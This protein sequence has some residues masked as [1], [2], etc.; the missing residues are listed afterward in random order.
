MFSFDSTL[1]FN[2]SVTITYSVTDRGDPD[3]CGAPGLG[4][5][6]AETS[7]IRTITTVNPVNDRPDAADHADAMDEDAAPL[8][9][10]LR[11]LV[12]DLETDDADLT[13]TIESGPTAAQGTFDPD[14]LDNGVFSFD[15][16]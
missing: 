7:E 2:G 13:Y 11:A 12:S 9:V 15:S 8:S 1:N 3:N 6:G 10:D 16:R 5:D 14:A 4:C